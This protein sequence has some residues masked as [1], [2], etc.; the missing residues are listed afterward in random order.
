FV[1]STSSLEV[2]P[3]NRRAVIPGDHLEIVKPQDETHLGFQLVVK[4]LLADA[5]PAGLWNSARVAVESRDFQK[6]IRTLEGHVAELDEPGLVQLALAYDSVGRSDDAIK[7]LESHGKDRTDAMG[8]LAGRLKRRW[9]LDHR[10]E[11]YHR[12]LQLY[13]DAL[14]LSKEAPDQRYYHAIN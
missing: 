13:S 4:T 12:A 2:F 7:L 6:A 3:E 10:E 8:T 1:P 11:D 14:E 5:A 9:L